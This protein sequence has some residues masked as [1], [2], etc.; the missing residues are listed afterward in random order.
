MQSGRDMNIV[1]A[2]V[3]P[4]D[5]ESLVEKLRRE[6]NASIFTEAERIRLWNGYVPK[7]LVLDI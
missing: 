2:I 3:L 4:L 5:D 7:R 6:E 1:A